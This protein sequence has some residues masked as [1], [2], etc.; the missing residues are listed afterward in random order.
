MTR[1]E[2]NAFAVNFGAAW[3]VAMAVGM[4]IV[5]LNS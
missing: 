2:R 4:L 1:P 3:E 5:W